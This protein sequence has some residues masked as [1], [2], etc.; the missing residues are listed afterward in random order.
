MEKESRETWVKA[1]PAQV[2]FRKLHSKQTLIFNA[3]SLLCLIYKRF[4]VWHNVK[5]RSSWLE[6]E[7]TSNYSCWTWITQTQPL[8]WPLWKYKIRDVFNVPDFKFVWCENG[9]RESRR[10]HWKKNSFL[11]NKKN[12]QTK[13]WLFLIFSGQVGH[14]C[15]PF[16]THLTEDV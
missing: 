11:K 10:Q 13:H 3:G 1:S 6:E 2:S 15:V 8:R 7:A 4:G 9:T 5:E 14:K 16:L 12:K